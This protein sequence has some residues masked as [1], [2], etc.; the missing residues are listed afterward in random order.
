MKAEERADDLI[1]ELSVFGLD[2]NI[3]ARAIREAE[4]QARKEA[5]DL[6]RD[7]KDWDIQRCIDAMHLNCGIHLALPQNLRARIQALIERESGE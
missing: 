2:R 1:H 6:I 7:I 4:Q 5:L 3:V